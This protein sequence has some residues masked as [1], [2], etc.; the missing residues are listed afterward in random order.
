[1]ARKKKESPQVAPAAETIC[2]ELKRLGAY[3]LNIGITGWRWLGFPTTIIATYF[4]VSP[5][6]EIM[7]GETMKQAKKTTL[8]A[9]KGKVKSESE[10]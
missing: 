5:A 10:V 9:I 3:E 1:M 2:T 7:A 4:F 6:G 8:A